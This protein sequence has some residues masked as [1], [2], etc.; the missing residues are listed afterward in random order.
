MRDSQLRSRKFL[1]SSS[2]QSTRRG[3]AS[4]LSHSL[5]VSLE[6]SYRY[7]KFFF[8]K[9]NIDRKIT[10]IH[11]NSSDSSLSTF[12]LKIPFCESAPSAARPSGTNFESI[13]VARNILF[14]NYEGICFYLSRG[15]K[16]IERSPFYRLLRPVDHVLVQ[17]REVKHRPGAQK[18]LAITFSREFIWETGFKIMFIFL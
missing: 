3:I 18:K 15:G 14:S 1:N 13:P 7:K 8:K 5:Q 9:N 17:D 4:F 11:L 6:N 12:L 2:E 10:A 16:Q